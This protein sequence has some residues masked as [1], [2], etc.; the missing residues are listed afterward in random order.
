MIGSRVRI[1]REVCGL[2]QEELAAA[3]GTTQSGVASIE[4]GI[5]VPSEGYI[6]KICTRTGFDASFF[7]KGEFP[8][9]PFGT[10]LYRAKASV[11]KPLKTRAHAFA[12]VALELAN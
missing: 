8:E 6:K 10:L 4:S 2:T 1:V 3:I 9:L 7:E 5:Y 12:Q 11:K